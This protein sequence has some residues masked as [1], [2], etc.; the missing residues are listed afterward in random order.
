MAN[1]DAQIRVSMANLQAS[2]QVSIANLDARTRTNI[3]NLQAATSIEVQN[4]QSDLAFS[5]QSRTLTHDAGMEQLRQ[6]GRIELSM[7]DGAIRQE[8][9]QYEID[10]KIDLSKLDHEQRL[11]VNEILQGYNLET[12]GK[13]HA[14]QRQ[15]LHVNMAMDAQNNYI[16]Y[17]VAFKDT[18]MDQAAITRLSDD[19][20]NHLLA[21][22][23]MI[24]GMF[25]EYPP[26]AARTGGAS[27]PTGG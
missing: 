16:N 5:M 26:I 3:A 25:P 4:L 17:M 27:G 6:E 13:D 18:D 20:W 19:A 24:N 14:F 21:E 10:G 11:A 8:L 2:T 9:L 23:S 12:Q 7:L 15:T 22:L 1:L